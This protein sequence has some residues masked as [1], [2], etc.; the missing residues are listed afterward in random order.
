VKDISVFSGFE[1]ALIQLFRY[2][3]M[4]ALLW[5]AP[6]KVTSVWIM[7]FHSDAL[8]VDMEAVKQADGNCCR[9]IYMRGVLSTTFF[10]HASCVGIDNS[11]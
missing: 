8:L 10:L 7:I 9:P 4:P 5:Y 3:L 1:I 6:G 11:F 2:L